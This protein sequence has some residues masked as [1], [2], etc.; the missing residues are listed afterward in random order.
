MI[1]KEDLTSRIVAWVLLFTAI[2][3][4]I[5]FGFGYIEGERQTE[6]Q[7]SENIIMFLNHSSVN[8]NLEFN[9]TRMIDYAYEKIN[10]S[11]LS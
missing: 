11:K 10:N 7:I 5:G 9:E 3:F 6:E 1:N 2:G 8:I 4:L